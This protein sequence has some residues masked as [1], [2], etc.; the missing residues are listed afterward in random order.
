MRENFHPVRFR[1]RTRGE[2]RK[3]KDPQRLPTAPG[4]RGGRRPYFTILSAWG[5]F[6]PLS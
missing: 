5:A 6:E 4:E 2:G 3:P 1:T